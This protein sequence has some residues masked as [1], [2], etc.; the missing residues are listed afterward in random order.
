[1][2]KG[3]PASCCSHTFGVCRL[4]RIYSTSGCSSQD[5]DMIRH[6]K[7]DKSDKDLMV[8]KPHSRP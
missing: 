7:R 3:A 5:S 6:C 2:V 8:C 4:D 1:M